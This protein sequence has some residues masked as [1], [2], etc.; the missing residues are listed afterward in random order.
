MHIA[1]VCRCFC[2]VCGSLSALGRIAPDFLGL[3]SSILIA[4][5][6]RGRGTGL[7]IPSSHVPV[8][9]ENDVKLYPCF[10]SLIC[11][12]LAPG[13]GALGCGITHSGSSL[14]RDPPPSSGFSKRR[15]PLSVDK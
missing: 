7:Q 9:P 15:T 6:T 14:P 10:A 1:S 8:M 4:L 12:T 3:G 5:L 11:D 2:F 13:W